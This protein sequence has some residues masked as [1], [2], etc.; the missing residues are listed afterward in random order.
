MLFDDAS[1]EPVIK[2]VTV[3]ASAKAWAG[4]MSAVSGESAETEMTLEASPNNH[5][6][7]WDFP[8]A[9]KVALSL[10][11]ELQR[12]L[13]VDARIL[14]RQDPNGGEEALVRYDAAIDAIVMNGE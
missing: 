10:R 1:L 9:Q 8:Q 4:S 14:Q 5:T 12:L 3:T 2:R 11:K 6:R 7:A 13:L